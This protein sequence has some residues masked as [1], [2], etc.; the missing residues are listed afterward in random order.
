[1]KRACLFIA[2]V[3]VCLWGAADALARGGRGGGRAGGGFSRGGGGFSGGGGYRGGGFSPSVSRPSMPSYSRPA[4]RP[5]V[6]RTSTPRPGVSSPGIS[7]RPSVSR[8]SSGLSRPSSPSGSR[9]S[10]GTLP[11]A[12]SRPGSGSRPG[13]ATRPNQ[14]GRP[15]AGDVR[16]FLDLPSTGGARPSQLPSSPRDNFGRG[17]AGGVAGGIAGSVAGD[18]L[19]DSGS[20]PSTLPAERPGIGNRPGAGDRPGMGERPGLGDRPLA[21]NRPE[22][23]ENRGDRQEIRQERRDEIRD[24]IDD[25]P[26]RD[27]WSDHPLWGA[28][29]ISRPFRWAAWGGVTGWVD[30]GWVEPI[31]YNYGENIY[32]QDGMV[33]SDGEVIATEEQYAQQAEAII[34]SA[35]EV[36][37]AAT[38]DAAEESDWMPLGVFA[39]TPDG[40]ESGPE[41]TLFLQLV[42]SKQGILSG[43]LN[44]ETTDTTQAIEGM[45]DKES[46]RSAWN[47]VGKTRPIMET[48][49]VNLTKDTAPVLVHFADGTTQQWLLVRLDDPQSEDALPGQ[50]E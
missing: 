8:P 12:G 50:S 16:D 21:G 37:A 18:F 23:I 14:G 9:P 6:P 33:Y 11:S 34:A 31:Y 26:I 44:D 1:M 22:R 20:R 30:Y 48:G 39:V 25:T 32:Y 36:D 45:V 15:S 10:A 3:A 35:P 49:I 17:I 43:T 38:E 13:A 19:R 28:W 27:F 41:P 2:I 40:Q 29:A 7:T 4:P 42:L 5:S 46:Q 47:V 24:Q